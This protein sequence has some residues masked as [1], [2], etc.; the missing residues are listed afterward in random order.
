MTILVPAGTGL[1][2]GRISLREPEPE[3]EMEVRVHLYWVCIG[4]YADVCKGAYAEVCLG[5]YSEVCLG[6]YSEAC[7]AISVCISDE[8]ASNDCV[9]DN[10]KSSPGTAAC[11]PK[12][13]R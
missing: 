7:I 13:V 11:A 12:C 8:T 2:E 4:A 5:A 1:C 6:A 9:S 10:V 3:W